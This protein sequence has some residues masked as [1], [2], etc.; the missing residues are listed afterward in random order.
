MK[1]RVLA[2][3]FLPRFSV[4][5][6]ARTCL[7]DT[8]WRRVSDAVRCES[9]WRCSICGAWPQPRDLH[10]HE[11]WEFSPDRQRLTGI[12]A[13]CRACHRCIHLDQ[14]I[15]GDDADY[16]ALT[17]YWNL[18]SHYCAVNQ[19]S[20]STFLRDLRRAEDRR[21]A[22]PPTARLLNIDA[23]FDYVSPPLRVYARFLDPLQA[24]S[25]VADPT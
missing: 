23:I 21:D 2:F 10:S 22:I 5:A 18:K 16:D 4:G 17:A 14:W 12:I 19:V 1:P 24:S 13:V 3:D 6:N 11:Q 8:D 7:V 20:E 9:G 15:P 25:S